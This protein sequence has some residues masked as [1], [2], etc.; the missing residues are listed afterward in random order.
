[1]GF[2]NTIVYKIELMVID[3]NG[4]FDKRPNLIIDLIENT[5]H[6]SPLVMKFESKEI[7]PWSDEHP[8]NSRDTMKKA[9]IELFEKK[10]VV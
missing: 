8:L 4:E 7:G 9:F 3:P 2:E 10:D 6:I 5:K 1:M